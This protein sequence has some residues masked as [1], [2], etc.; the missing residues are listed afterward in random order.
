MDTTLRP[1]IP[2]PVELGDGL[3]LRRARPDDAEALAA[4]GAAVHRLPG[5][6]EDDHLIAGWVRELLVRPHPTSGPDLFTVVEDAAGNVV[7]T[8]GL[9]PQTWSYD[10]VP[11]G[12]G[13][14]ELVGTLP[15]FRRRGLV[16]TQMAVAHGWSAERGLL[17]QAITGRSWF[18][19]QFG[20]EMTVALGGGR[21][22]LVHRVP[23]LQA[24]ARE[25]FHVRPA[26]PADLEFIATVDARG[27]SRYLVTCERDAAAWHHE[28]DPAGRREGMYRTVLAVIERQA[29]DGDAAPGAAVGFVAHPPGLIGTVL[30]V[31]AYELSAGVSWLE[32]TPSVLRYL[33]DAGVA[34][35]AAGATVVAGPVAGRCDAIFF[36]WSAEHPA[37]AALP[38][39]AAPGNPPYAWY[40]RVPDLPAFLHRVAPVLE[41]RLATSVAPGHTGT[42]T[43]NFYRAGLRL[44]FVDGRVAEVEPVPA[45]EEDEADASFP[46]FTFLHLL[47][48][49]RSLADLEYA[50]ADCSVQSGRARALLDALFPRRPSL[51]WPLA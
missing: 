16:R 34:Y 36:H 10:G 30:T 11:F 6:A 3:T 1:P 15:A 50:F 38:D 12:V 19:R 48:G 9:I 4:F 39:P 46:D 37:F 41:A 23:N 20:Y 27:R 18:Y 44:A 2:L 35:A 49:H 7:S 42:L 21:R 32:A 17:A 26:T 28:L 40:L 43:L 45:P 33:R 47:F 13:R 31:N 29:A 25:P 8:L 24:E 14:V 5:A 51:V 22:V